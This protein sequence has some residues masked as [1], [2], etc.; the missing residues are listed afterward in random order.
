MIYVILNVNAL[1]P[2]LFILY[3]TRTYITHPVSYIKASMYILLF[4]KCNTI[5]S[6]FLTWI[7]VECSICSIGFS[8]ISHWP[9]LLLSVLQSPLFANVVNSAF[10]IRPLL[11]PSERS[12]SHLSCWIK[13]TNIWYY[14][15]PHVPPV[16]SFNRLSK[17]K[18]FKR[19]IFWLPSLNL[20]NKKHINIF[21]ND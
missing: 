11:Q 12:L 2:T 15:R 10:P 19:D 1:K 8:C 9:S 21:F 16:N 3:N 7:R 14:T 4:E 18:A 6:I 13:F 20:K 17:K 5:D